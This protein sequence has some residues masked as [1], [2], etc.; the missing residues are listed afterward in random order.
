MG[1]WSGLL[2]PRQ[3]SLQ[4]RL[5]GL[6]LETV[7]AKAAERH[8]WTPERTSAALADYRRF[9]ILLARH[10]A[11]TLV[12]WTEDLDL[13]WH[14]HILDTRRYRRDC[15]ALAGREIHHDPHIRRRPDEE[16][17]ARRDTAGLLGSEFGIAAGGLALLA[18]TPAI[19]DELAQ[20]EERRKDGG[21]GAYV[22]GGGSSENND[23]GDASGDS[24]GGGDGASS[25]GG[26][27]CGG[28]GGCGGS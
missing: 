9:L 25:C 23:G 2:A 5:D 15:M 16:A 8:G 4:Q 3:K 20:A 18:V 24:G 17:R 12:P 6:G 1:F 28:G 26:S 27:S 13:L 7:A 22:Y 11:K 14:E 10:P 21:C 19:A